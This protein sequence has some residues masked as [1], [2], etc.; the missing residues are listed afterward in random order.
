MKFLEEGVYLCTSCDSYFKI[1]GSSKSFIQVEE[2]YDPTEDEI[3]NIIETTQEN[4]QPSHDCTE[5]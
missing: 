1:T 3:I 2:N 4:N 5:F